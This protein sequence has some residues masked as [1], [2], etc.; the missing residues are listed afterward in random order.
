MMGMSYF[1]W[2]SRRKGCHAAL[3]PEQWSKAALG[4]LARQRSAHHL[5]HGCNSK[6]K[7]EWD[8]GLV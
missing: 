6:G 7:W 5:L 8:E 2:G 3:N 1:Q 4:S